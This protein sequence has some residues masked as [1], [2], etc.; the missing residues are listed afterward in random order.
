[1]LSSN[2]AR[3]RFLRQTNL[4][5]DY[6][7]SVAISLLRGLAALQVAAAHVRA[8]FYPGLSTIADPAAGYQLLA[9]VTGFA[10]QAV[11]IFFLLSGWLVGGSLMNKLD[12]PHA[13]L[14]YCIDRI[15][16]LWIV[17]VP[18]FA[19]SLLVGLFVGELASWRAGGAMPEAYAPLTFIGNMFGLQ[20]LAFP[21]YGGNFALWSLTY[22]TWYYAMFP[23]AV[24]MF[25]RPGAFAKAASA[26]ALAVIAWHL[27]AAILL[28]F[29]LWLMG[30]GF[31]RIH[32]QA[33]RQLQWGLAALFV[34]VAVWFR[35]N[36]SNNIL[37]EESYL[38]DLLYGLLFLVLLCSL[39][40]Q[41]APGDALMLRLGRIGNFFAEFSF[42]LYVIHVPLIFLLRHVNQRQF[43]IAQLDPA[44][45]SDFGVYLSL[46]V[47]IVL[48][49]W[50]F[51]LPFEAQTYRL[52]RRLKGWLLP[53]VA[54][55]NIA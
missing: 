21:R 54:A 37:T 27:N 28:Y 30:A 24:L 15:S 5:T 35:I 45:L 23:L 2:F 53:P 55:Q 3:V 38:Q 51:H 16:R 17:L 6:Q 1:M 46:V 50:L 44:S 33:G 14:A 8:Q 13:L 9:F 48:L 41:V 43:G 31:S 25:A 29:T 47:V 39:Q 19:V 26:V 11:V 12:Q 40:T 36:G 52:R 49:A 7:H 20:D 18:A 10:H 22:E 42:S 4:R 34:L 32:I